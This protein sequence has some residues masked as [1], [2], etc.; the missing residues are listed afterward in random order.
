MA[1]FSVHSFPKPPEPNAFQI[2]QLMALDVAKAK[3]A[4][5]RVCREQGATRTMTK[6]I[7]H[8][9]FNLNEGPTE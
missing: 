2:S 7:V 4:L 1:R 8:D 6:R 9:Y 3:R 5:E